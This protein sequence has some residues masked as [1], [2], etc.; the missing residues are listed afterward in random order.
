M[1]K[2]FFHIVMLLV[3]ADLAMALAGYGA[4]YDQA[5]VQP[6]QTYY[7]EGE[8]PAFGQKAYALLS[9]NLGY[10]TGRFRFSCYG[11]NLAD[12]RYYSAITPGT[13]HGTPG[14][15]RTWG[16]EVRVTW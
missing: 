9:A 4:N 3:I 10:A 12:K 15:P 6:G 8:E 2:Y 16:A 13:N 1:K 5:V 7:T 14:A 11:E